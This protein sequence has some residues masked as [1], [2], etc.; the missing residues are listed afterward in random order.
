MDRRWARATCAGSRTAG[1]INRP[2]QRGGEKAPVASVANVRQRPRPGGTPATE[3]RPHLSVRRRS[4][5]RPGRGGCPKLLG[6]ASRT[7]RPGVRAGRGAPWGP[8]TR[9]GHDLQRAAIL[10]PPPML[11]FIAPR[12]PDEGVGEMTSLPSRAAAPLRARPHSPRT[13]SCHDDVPRRRRA[14]AGGPAPHRR[15]PGGGGR[16][17][18]AV[19]GSAL[20]SADLSPSSP[21]R[22]SGRLAAGALDASSALA[23]PAACC[24][25]RGPPWR[26]PI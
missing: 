16:C 22:T 10:L 7:C 17:P 4:S 25:A 20:F 2:L 1:G 15:R 9:L 14:C 21:V 19:G 12:G 6:F 18:L 24:S 8:S 23:R 13:P 11:S 3:R 5:P 26:R